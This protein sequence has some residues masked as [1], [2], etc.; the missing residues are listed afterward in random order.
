MKTALLIDD[1]AISRS[2]VALLLPGG[3]WQ[4][5][6]AED[7]EKGLELAAQHRPELIVCDLMMPRHNGFYVCRGIRSDPAR[8]STPK[9][10]V[11]TGSAY[12][13]DKQSALT[14]GADAVLVKPV[15]QAEFLAAIEQPR[16]ASHPPS[17]GSNRKEAAT[18]AP[19]PGNYVKFWGVRG[20]LPVPGPSTI[21]HGGNTSCV[22]VRA[23]GELIVLDAGTGIR[24]LGLALLGEF[25]TPIKFTLLI[26]HTHWDH[27]QGF[28]FFPAA[29]RPENSI[30]ILSFESTSKDLLSILSHQMESPY[31]PITMGTMPGNLQVEELRDL[32]FKIGSIEVRAMFC[33]HPGVCAAYRLNTSKGSVVYMPDNEL[34]GPQ[35]AGANDPE[36]RQFAGKKDAEFVEF[37]R[38]CNVLIID[39]QYDRAEYGRFVGWGHSCW[40]DDVQ[41]AIAAGVKRLVLFHHDPSHDDARLEAKAAGARKLAGASGSS[42]VVECAKEGASI[43]F[44]P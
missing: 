42:L 24:N 25:K 7:G 8:Y 15:K 4:V 16:V 37:A 21:G 33:N 2:V 36:A 43:S 3:E 44:A 14:A 30:R 23:D 13:V 11:T 38:G 27:I 20:S 17:P 41:L 10:I 5:L 1:D 34:L 6:E 26:T 29:Y 32:T 12:A 31:F 9:I 18:Y 39:S 35:K 19:I 40:E 22:E 28:P